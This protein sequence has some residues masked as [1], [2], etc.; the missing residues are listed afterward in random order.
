MILCMCCSLFFSNVYATP[1]SA[2]RHLDEVVSAF[3]HVDNVD[4]FSE[5]LKVGRRSGR[6]V[7][8]PEHIETFAD[9]ARYIDDIAETG[10]DAPKVKQAKKMLEEIAIEMGENPNAWR[11]M[12]SSRAIERQLARS[13]EVLAEASDTSRSNRWGRKKGRGA[14]PA[15]DVARRA[16]SSPEDS[17]ITK[18]LD[19]ATDGSLSRRGLVVT[20]NT[21]FSKEVLSSMLDLAARQRYTIEETLEAFTNPGKL[22]G[23]EA[24][25]VRILKAAG[26]IPHGNPHRA[27]LLA[28]LDE[29]A[30]AESAALRRVDE[31][32][33][34]SPDKLAEE[35]GSGLSALRKKMGL[36]KRGARRVLGRAGQKVVHSVLRVDRRAAEIITELVEGTQKRMVQSLQGRKL[37]TRAVDG[38]LE[39]VELTESN[40]KKIVKTLEGAEDAQLDKFLRMTDADLGGLPLAKRL[41]YL[42]SVEDLITEYRHGMQ[43]T[44]ETPIDELVQYS[45][46]LKRTLEEMSSLRSASSHSIAP[47]QVDELFDGSGRWAGYLHQMQRRSE[48]VDE[49]SGAIFS[50]SKLT[51]KVMRQKHVSRII[52]NNWILRELYEPL[53]SAASRVDDVGVIYDDTVAVLKNGVL[54]NPGSYGDIVRKFGSQLSLRE[55]KALKTQQY[56]LAGMRRSAID[57]VH[58][59][60]LANGVR[61]F[62]LKSVDVLILGTAFSFIGYFTKL[63]FINPNAA[64][65]VEIIVDYKKKFFGMEAETFELAMMVDMNDRIVRDIISNGQHK[66]DERVSDIDLLTT[67]I[68]DLKMSLIPLKTEKA[69]IYLASPEVKKIVESGSGEAGELSELVFIIDDIDRQLA[70]REKLLQEKSDIMYAELAGIGSY[71]HQYS[72]YWS[73]YAQYLATKGLIAIKVDLNQS[74][75]VYKSIRLEYSVD[76]Q[77]EPIIYNYD[78][79]LHKRFISL[80]EIN[81]DFSMGIVR[82]KL[83][84]AVLISEMDPSISDKDLIKQLTIRYDQ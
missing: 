10:S 51:S 38:S 8:L 42:S 18:F 21:K 63:Y 50:P 75:G 22:K 70:A 31:F 17:I 55:L 37:V 79:E 44:F 77:E 24:K 61:R 45:K 62:R 78:V 60:T 23:F 53:E 71:F 47:S 14:R 48:V 15:A 82:T 32:L 39:T 65:L 43:Q 12:V 84:W 29:L 69:K 30:S 64:S 49:I 81:N 59:E 4:S 28:K 68:R 3:K 54:E 20:P 52:E 56:S 66:L 34:S 72:E 74:T 1:V 16:L 46:N 13:S 57:M 35:F 26:D 25:R 9:L 19:A 2:L 67:E 40:I 33:P 6:I 73:K 11:K 27:T 7:N 76:Y 58:P 83:N 36:E 5:F 80:L 41:E